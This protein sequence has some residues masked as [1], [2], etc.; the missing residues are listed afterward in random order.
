MKTVDFS[1]Q[2]AWSIAPAP[3]VVLCKDGSMVAGWTIQGYDH[4]SASIHDRA[5]NSWRM[6]AALSGF[7]QGASFWVEFTRRRERTY[8]GSAEEFDMP[9]LKLMQME[10]S[11]QFEDGG[12]LFAV[13][14]RLYVQF[15]AF[16]ETKE[17][18]ARIA[19]FEQFCLQVESRFSN[20]FRL[21]RLRAETLT[22]TAG[23]GYGT[24][25]LISGLG[26]A[27][28]GERRRLRLPPGT[29]PFKLNALMSPEVRREHLSSHVH[30]DGAPMAVIAIDGYPPYTS[31]G[32]M[33][34]L[35]HL[36]FDYRWCSRF[37][38]LGANAGRKEITKRRRFW[39]QEKTSLASQATGAQDSNADRFAIRMEDETDEVL[40]AIAQGDLQYGI[41]SGTLTI[42]G[43]RQ[44]SDDAETLN[45]AI[46]TVRETLLSCGFEARIETFN[47]LDAWLGSLPGHAHKNLRR[48]MLSTANFGDMVPLSTTWRGEE[49]NPCSLFP[50]NSSALFTARA[51]SGEPYYFN[52]HSGNVGHSL[53]FGPTDAGKSVLLGFL[54]AN[55]MR[56]PNGRVI[57]FDKRRSMMRLTRAVDG[58]FVDLGAEARG[59]NPVGGLMAIS[60]DAAAEWLEQ[61]IVLTDPEITDRRAIRQEIRQ[62][63]NL[64]NEKT[65]LEEIAN[66]IQHDAAR[67]AFAAYLTPEKKHIFS[68]PTDQYSL[69]RWTVFELNDLFEFDRTTAI[70]VIDYLF[71]K[72]EAQLDG[73]PTLIVIDEAWAFISHPLFADRIKM[74]LKE[75][76]KANAS[77]VMA[78]QAV[79][80]TLDTGITSAL[81]ESCFTKIFLPNPAAKTPQGTAQYLALGLTDAQIDIITGMQRH[82]DYYITKPEGSRVVDLVLGRATLSLI[83]R[84]STEDSRAADEAYGD[85]PN[86]WEE[87]VRN[88]LAI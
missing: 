53:I 32:V 31:A 37:I 41:Y 86:F 68:S 20:V 16:N 22:D 7:K 3:G 51:R 60:K 40:A 30:V 26:T 36:P 84:T 21:M 17:L 50:S 39:A 2:L 78:T 10:R 24:D 45:Q 25:E 63:L 28:K 8:V 73:Q 76:R 6:A 72:I 67:A 15:S 1:D 57:V 87:D 66:L 83:G 88:V 47:A 4:E 82:R 54:A 79:S 11:V 33:E 18:K 77:V 85:N 34:R 55:W 61:M 56:Y 14:T 71:R 81:L 64:A 29:V 5:D 23:E 27:L 49:T 38:C 44:D 35:A 75:L 48:P 42:F 12:D 58:T 13:E 74:W 69:G 46:E 43:S 70:L 19:Q 9:A 65:T 62:A 59:L 52:L 80:D